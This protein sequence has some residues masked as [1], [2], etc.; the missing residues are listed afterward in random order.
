VRA[1][2]RLKDAV[3]L[4]LVA[5]VPVVAVWAA[6]MDPVVAG[7]AAAEHVASVDATVLAG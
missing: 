7:R 5:M 6:A 3:I 1:C 4:E 2:I